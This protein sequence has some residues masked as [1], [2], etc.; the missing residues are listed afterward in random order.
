MGTDSVDLKV[1]RSGRGQ[2]MTAFAIGSVIHLKY[3]SI[4]DMWHSQVPDYALLFAGSTVKEG[5]SYVSYAE[6]T[7]WPS[8]PYL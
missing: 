2:D 1:R 6:P 8:E 3:Y 4:I 5:V 7:S